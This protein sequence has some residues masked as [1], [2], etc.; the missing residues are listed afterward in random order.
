MNNRIAGRDVSDGILVLLPQLVRQVELI[1]ERISGGRDREEDVND[2][3]GVGGVVVRSKIPFDGILT[4][5]YGRRDARARGIAGLILLSVRGSAFPL[6]G[7]RDGR[8]GRIE[9][10]RGSVRMRRVVR[11]RVSRIENRKR[12]KVGER[13]ILKIAAEECI[14]VPIRD[15]DAGRNRDRRTDRQVSGDRVD[16]FVQRRHGKCY[17]GA[18][19]VLHAGTGRAKS[20]SA[21]HVTLNRDRVGQRVALLETGIAGGI[22]VCVFVLDHGAE[23]QCAGRRA[24]VVRAAIRRRTART[25][26]NTPADESSIRSPVRDEFV[27]GAEIKFGCA[28]G[29]R[30]TAAAGVMWFDGIVRRVHRGGGQGVAVAVHRER[31]RECSV[32]LLTVGHRVGDDDVLEREEIGDLKTE[33]VCQ[34]AAGLGVAIG[35]ALLN[36]DGF[37]VQSVR[38]DAVGDD[39]TRVARINRRPVSLSGGSVD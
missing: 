4:R 34:D 33:S 36:R 20:A 38:S 15:G 10:P 24:V 29:R 23:D 32:K 3:R 39:S 27:G 18:A 25:W 11:V 31:W 14:R 8:A 19:I 28:I 22:I 9:R 16:R 5:V 21:K 17:V 30:R 2:P 1:G 7:W 12:Q 35:D 26:V 13:K 6:R 37:V